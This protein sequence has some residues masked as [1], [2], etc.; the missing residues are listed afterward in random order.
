MPKQRKK[1]SKT[2]QR[3]MKIGNNPSKLSSLKIVLSV[4]CLIALL[5]TAY[6]VWQYYEGQKPPEI[7]DSSNDSFLGGIAPDFTYRDINGTAVTLSQ[8][9][10]EVIVIH[11]M[12]VGC[13]GQI[14]QVN[15][16]QLAQLK[17]V[18]NSF[19]NDESVSFLSVAVATCENS[20]LDQ[21]RGTYGV[22][23]A[24]GNDFEDNVLDIVNSYVPQGIGDGTVV[25]IDKT[26]NIVEVYRGGVAE[27]TLSTK[28]TA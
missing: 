26:F 4:I 7:G 11:F 5:I 1:S 12:A 14:N 3:K 22:T 8:F 27:S 25:L 15:H 13:G 24:F 18:C 23:W 10:D 20:E 6:G 28:I 16:Y 2:K 21:I 17:N 19:C 9:K